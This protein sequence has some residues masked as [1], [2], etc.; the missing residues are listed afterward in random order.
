MS[1]IPVAGH[2]ERAGVGD[3]DGSGPVRLHLADVLGI[4]PGDGALHIDV[5]C[6]VLGRDGKPVAE[7]FAI[8]DVNAVASY[9]HTASYQAEIVCT[10]LLG[11]GRD[12]NHSAIPRVVCTD[13][14]SWVGG[15]AVVGP[16]AGSWVGELVDRLAA[17][18]EG[19]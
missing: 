13:P 8:G 2:K 9:T 3:H 6:R 18:G 11:H 14:D 5:S 19:A 17:V 16:P 12:T 1:P 7:V 15:T 10:E 4:D